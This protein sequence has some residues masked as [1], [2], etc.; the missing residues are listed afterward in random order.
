[1]AAVIFRVTRR[2]IFYV[3]V[4]DKK[5]RWRKTY[6]RLQWNDSVGSLTVRTEDTLMHI[7]RQRLQN[8]DRQTE[9]TPLCGIER[10]IGTVL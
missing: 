6:Y 8:G 9:I 10:D 2:F 1:M 5:K 3:I 7:G 4:Q